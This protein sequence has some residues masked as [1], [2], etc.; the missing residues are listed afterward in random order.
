[1]K[2]Y[3]SKLLDEKNRQ[4]DMALLSVLVA[5]VMSIILSIAILIPSVMTTWKTGKIDS[6]SLSILGMWMGIAFGTMAADKKWGAQLPQ[7]K[8][9]TIVPP[10]PEPTKP[11]E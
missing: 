4:A 8:P 10:K 3:L 11:G 6:G 1:M 2:E 5:I 9:K 7:P